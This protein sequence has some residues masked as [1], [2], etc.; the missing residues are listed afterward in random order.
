[1]KSEKP[2]LTRDEIKV[3][4]SLLE[5]MHNQSICAHSMLLCK[6]MRNAQYYNDL[7]STFKMI[8]EV[9]KLLL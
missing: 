5:N 2:Y 7:L 1:M 9:T 3:I 4:N 8:R 6:N